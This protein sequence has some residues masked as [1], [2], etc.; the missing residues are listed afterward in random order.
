MILVNYWGANYWEAI[1]KRRWHVRR[2]HHLRHLFHISYCRLHWLVNWHSTTVVK[3]RRRH[4]L[5][6]VVTN[7]WVVRGRNHIIDNYIGLAFAQRVFETLPVTIVAESSARFGRWFVVNVSLPRNL[8]QL[9]D[10]RT[11]LRNSNVDICS[12]L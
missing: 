8:N 2:R 1:L 12:D 3:R 9:L 11:L 4:L 10:F 7:I 6:H 5:I